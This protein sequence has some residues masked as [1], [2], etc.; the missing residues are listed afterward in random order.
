[1]Q[2]EHFTLS[3]MQNYTSPT[4]PNRSN[5]EAAKLRELPKRWAKKATVIA[6]IGALSIGMLTGLGAASA[7]SHDDA[8]P[9]TSVVYSTQNSVGLDVVIRTH[10]GGSAAGPYYVAYLTEQEALG[11]IRDRLL[12]MG[13][14]FN[15]PVPDYV[16]TLDV[17]NSSRVITARL[18]FFD[19]D[20]RQ[21][22]IFPRPW[23]W[24]EEFQF[25]W[26][27]PP[28]HIENTLRWQ[29]AEQFD[30][31][32]TFM[33][34]LGKRICDG[35]YTWEHG[36]G[37]P[38]FTQE[39]KQTAGQIV[40]GWLE[41]QVDTFIEQLRNDE[42]LPPA[43]P[44]VAR[45]RSSVML[46]PPPSFS[47][48]SPTAWYADAV[49]TMYKEGYITGTSP[50]TFAPTQA[51]SRGQVVTI[52]YRMAGE[53]AVE[54]QPTF[55]D[56]PITA[57][58]WYRDAVIWASENGIVQGFDGRFD[59]YSEITREQFATIL[60]RFASPL[61]N[62]SEAQI[63]FSDADQISSWAE[64]A[65]N[66]AVESGIIQGAGERLNPQ[67]TATRAQGTVMLSR[68]MELLS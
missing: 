45:L 4:Y 23:S 36:G 35:A 66:W 43:P 38:T 68:L 53:P 61:D 16:V 24:W 13:V 29:F 10:H 40:R 11:V 7:T 3:P 63:D 25:F 31:T 46:P 54:F 17:P 52:L 67:G 19:E 59:P 20:T 6:C 32:V 49:R 41:S 48:I 50:T 44:L 34:N 64:Y 47:D 2:N 14:G 60:Y 62:Q 9:G 28:N 8:T 26:D 18:S 57:P 33:D 39:E 12:F 27:M 58:A 51:L 56:V 22:I 1:M 42:I 5:I 65:M 15:S 21:G 37:E 30:V 55:S